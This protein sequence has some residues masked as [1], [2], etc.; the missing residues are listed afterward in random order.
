[1]F[2]AYFYTAIQFDPVRTADNLRK[3]GGFIPGIRPGPPTASYLNDILVRITLPG[4]L[5]LA[6]IAL[7]P[8]IV[9][10]YW[11]FSPVPVRRHVG[12]DRRRRRAGDDEADR[13]AAADASLRRLPEVGAAMRLV[14]L[15]P[16]GAGKGTQAQRLSERVGIPQISTGDILREHVQ[17]GTPLG[18]KARGFMDR[19]EYVP[20]DVVVE[21]V[22]DRLDGPTPRRASS[23]TGSRGPSRR[24]RPSSRALERAERPLDAVLMFAITDEMAVR[25]L[26][27]RWTCPTCKR[28]Y[29]MEFKPPAAD[30]VCDLDQTE[31]ERRADDDELTVRRRLAVY[32]EQTEPLERFYQDRGLLREIDAEAR[33]DDVTAADARRTGGGRMIIRKSSDELGGCAVRARS[34][35]RRSRPCSTRCAPA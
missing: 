7:I 8:S 20:D 17:E 9:F 23:S 26:S 24:P 4:S 28:T 34:R 25:R 14:L 22:M 15:G 29:N 5:F 30:Q 32:D 1:M 16:P 10:A 12:A 3:Q 6:A 11:A 2:F 35:P 27:N 21:M 31:L 33:E 18:V 13:V 19:G